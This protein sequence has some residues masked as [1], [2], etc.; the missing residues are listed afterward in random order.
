MP[1]KFFTKELER[2]RQR[3]R[4]RKGWREEVERGL[5]ALG[6]R[7]WREL[8]TNREKLRGITRQAK[9]HSGL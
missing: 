1:K 6:V 9:A 7:I 2:T 3:G 4:P 5:Q 8:V